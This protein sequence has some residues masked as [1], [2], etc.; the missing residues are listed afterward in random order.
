MVKYTG[1]NH[2]YLTDIMVVSIPLL[3]ALLSKFLDKLSF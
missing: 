1:N 2:D 3:L